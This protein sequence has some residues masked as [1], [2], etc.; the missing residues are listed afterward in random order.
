MLP[1]EKNVHV[2]NAFMIIFLS[3]SLIFISLC[4][5][6]R[7]FHNHIR[8]LHAC[9]DQ[10]SCNDQF[11]RNNVQFI[12]SFDPLI[13][14]AYST[15]IVSVELI[16]ATHCS[17]HSW[18]INGYDCLLPLQD[19]PHITLNL[20]FSFWCPYHLGLKGSVVYNG[21]VNVINIRPQ[22]SSPS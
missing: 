18:Q 1:E 10:W 16:I 2:V 3:I 21:F 14:F 22:G 17:L 8:L 19:I 20:C 15:S 9:I 4:T 5:L 7:A 13:C 11:S 6:N 12:K